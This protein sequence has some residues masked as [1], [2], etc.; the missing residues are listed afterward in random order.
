MVTKVKRICTY[1]KLDHATAGKVLIQLRT[2]PEVCNYCRIKPCVLAIYI[3][4]TKEE[5]RKK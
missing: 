3:W 4:G 5:R 2:H 1:E